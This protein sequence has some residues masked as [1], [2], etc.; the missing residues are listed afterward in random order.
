MNPGDVAA[1]VR[2][3]LQGDR[4]AFHRLVAAF[5]LP[6]RSYL[7][8][9]VY[10]LDDVDDIAQEVFI[11]A[12]RNLDRFSPDGSFAAWLRGIARNEVL[13]YFRSESRRESL[14]DRFRGEVAQAVG[15]EF[16]RS[17]AEDR[18]E[19]IERLLHCVA[20]LPERLRRVVRAG[21]AGTKAA[22]LAAELGT[23]TAA[24]YNLHYRANQLLRTCLQ[25]E[26]S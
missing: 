7:A 20:R 11:T 8:G 9:Q 26:P 17:T 19:V 25:K 23:S 22:A 13:M 16:D 3:V 4:D 5:G 10:R 24:V 14:L 15:V 21:L 6:L 2:A 12:Y 18:T 1:I